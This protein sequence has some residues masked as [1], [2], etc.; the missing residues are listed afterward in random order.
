[1]RNGAAKRTR[2]ILLSAL[3]CAA[4]TA[5]AS[6]SDALGAFSEDR[7]EY[8]TDLFLD[9]AE[10][11]W[12]ESAVKTVVQKGV[13]NGAGDVFLPDKPMSWAEA[14]TITA[15]IHAL[16][17][18][19]EIPEG[20]DGA[21]YQRYWDYVADAGLLPESAPYAWRAETVDVSRED[22]CLLMRGV[23]SGR[24][25][26]PINDSAVP[27][28]D[29]ARNSSR[30]AVCELYAAGVF[31]G[32]DG[33]YFHPAASATRAEIATVV[34]R[35]I[36]P[37]QRVGADS[38]LDK[39]MAGQYG[40]FLV[41]GETV[42][43]NGLSYYLVRTT[44]Y[45]AASDRTTL[46]S[47][48]VSRADSGAVETVYRTG[49]GLTRLGADESGRLYFVETTGE[50]RDWRCAL[51]RLDAAA[52][53]EPE[54]LYTTDRIDC[55][56]LYDGEIYLLERLGGGDD[57][58]SWSYR[59]G[60]LAGRS[61]HYLTPVMR[62]DETLYTDDSLY[63]FAGKLYYLFGDG[64]YTANGATGHSYSLYEI[65]LANGTR[66]KLIDGAGHKNLYLGEIAYTGATAWFLGVAEDGTR[67]LKRANLRLPE[68]IETVAAVPQEANH[69]YVTM[70]ANGAS[71]YYNASS[72]KR[73]WEISPAGT[74]AQRMAMD[75]WPE[76]EH[77]AVTPQGILALNS[78]TVVLPDGRETSYRGFL[79]RP[80][81]IR[82]TTRFAA[83]SDERIYVG[84]KMRAE[85]WSG[86]L[87][88][89]FR[90]EDGSYVAEIR[91][92]NGTA[93]DVK[94]DAIAFECRIGDMTLRPRF[95]VSPLA[96]GASKVY[97]FVVPAQTLGDAAHA[98]KTALDWWYYVLE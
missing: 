22:L 41:N 65:D 72:T 53:G 82:G 49:N 90:T 64:A 94:L 7:A 97:T 32:K 17:H 43:W 76:E 20:A 48:I 24:D 66:A 44:Q 69:N 3:L 62:F 39:T 75:A 30:D 93:K 79:G 5:G 92:V 57:P 33:G 68:L 11:A 45:D 74:F 60:R 19:A 55:Y 78:D 35:L 18:G 96:A 12:Y 88:R 42:R 28:L 70:F 63:C 77:P 25:L 61:L 67:V 27:D 89:E 29:K 54:T 51:R 98:E 1:M 81:L 23:L 37:A 8:R 13:M 38:R 46:L 16:Y 2:T 47:E 59:I 26:P 56:T 91:L 15:R 36:C 34:T 40:N 87:V 85:D 50:K 52:K 95:S 21:W 31:T 83:A 9:V 84:P 14:V 71:L 73:L 80:Y 58:K 10:G 4:L 6:A 86:G